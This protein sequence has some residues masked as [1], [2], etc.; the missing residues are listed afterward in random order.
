MTSSLKTTSHTTKA[1]GLS[2]KA[3]PK[4]EIKKTVS[5]QSSVPEKRPVT[6]K[7]TS[8]P[9]EVL[10]G[11]SPQKAKNTPRTVSAP[12]SSS[13]PLRSTK[14]ILAKTMR[15]SS[16][17]AL[18]TILLSSMF[19][20]TVKLSVVATV[21]FTGVYG[22]YHVLGTSFADEV[23]ISKSEILSRAKKHITLP[24]EAPTRIVRVQ[25][26]DD[27]KKQNDFYKDVKVGD[28]IIMYQSVAIIYDLRNDALVSVKRTETESSSSV[29]TSF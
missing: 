21:A 22:I 11:V 25:D 17:K 2:K 18:R 16:K 5:L 24:D 28:Y 14:K 12:R 1:R 27:L 10:K 7:K 8:P 29:P 9:S 4:H 13:T 15:R 19:H 20:T 23:V 26:S 3:G 6:R